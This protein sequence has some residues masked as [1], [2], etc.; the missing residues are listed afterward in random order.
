MTGSGRQ[1][2]ENRSAL[3]DGETYE[4][5]LALRITL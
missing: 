5:L 3:V 1:R 4:K 2:E